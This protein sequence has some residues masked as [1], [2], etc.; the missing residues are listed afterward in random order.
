MARQATRVGWLDTVRD[1]S[2]LALLGILTT[3][4]AL[5]V[6]TTAA[7]V[8]TASTALHHWQEHG[9]W[10][11][12]RDITHR[13]GRALLPGIPVTLLA[14]AAGG[15]LG[16]NLTA[17]D[18]GAVP[19]GTALF[20]LTLALVVV[21]VGYA[22][23]VVVEVGRDNAG[24]RAAARR[25]AA[26]ARRHPNAVAALS[27][28]TLLAGILAVTVIPVAAPILVGYLLFAQHAVTR[29]LIPAT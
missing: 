17:F 9:Y 3:V 4:G 20:Y 16:L 28:V 12:A 24:W 26:G 23:L 10:P 13:Y 11:T 29:R 18:N 1:A 15:L 21:V 14:A 5:G 2:D 19:G 7:A 6:V 25:A 22:S 27:G 8:A